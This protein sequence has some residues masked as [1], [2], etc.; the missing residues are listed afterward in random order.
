M[1]IFERR[2]IGE[3]LSKKACKRTYEK[4]KKVVKRAIKTDTVAGKNMII[5]LKQIPLLVEI[6]LY[7]AEE[8]FEIYKLI[9]EIM[10]IR[11]NRDEK[12]LGERVA[13]LSVRR[14]AKAVGGEVVE[15]EKE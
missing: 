12:M 14:I 8:G 13:D 9:S 6:G 10:K 1:H 15:E 2:I 7:T 3:K 11:V 4:D 5:I